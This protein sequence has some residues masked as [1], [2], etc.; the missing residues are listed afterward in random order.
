MRQAKK[1]AMQGSQPPRP[2][3]GVARI[4][5]VNL[6]LAASLGFAACGANAPGMSALP[7]PAG[8]SAVFNEIYDGDFDKNNAGAP[9]DQFDILYVAFGHIDPVTHRLDFETKVGK[10]IERQRLE[11]ICAPLTGGSP[12]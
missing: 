9:Y 1:S 10:E 8:V 3:G 12:S 11:M 6:L 5:M 4:F 2:A 7:P